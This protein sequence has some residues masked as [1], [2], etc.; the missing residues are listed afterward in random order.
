MI[1]P[2]PEQVEQ[3]MAERGG[4][5]FR[6]TPWATAFTIL[7]VALLIGLGTWQLQRLEWKEEL[8]AER[9]TRSTDSAVPL[10]GDLSD[11]KALDYVRVE[12]V[13]RFLHDKELY[14]GSRTL[15]GSVGYHVVTPFRLSD[16][17]TLLVNRGW[18]PP[19]RRDPES[20]AA[21]QLDGGEIRIEALLR[22]GGWRGWS[23]TRPANDP[24][25]N[26]WLWPDLPAMF[27][28]LGAE[29]AG[30]ERPVTTLYAESLPVGPLAELPGGL[31]VAVAGAIDLRN[32][33]LE[34]A[35]TWYALALALLIIYLIYSTRRGAAQP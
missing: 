11:S 18:V 9:H 27:A 25:G 7:G 29:A 34:Y 4:R 19:E 23:F 31:P 26:L 33:H 32:E 8:I 2:M 10:P 28:A 6:P 5:R 1:D 13:G 14:L 20:R 21:G 30:L 35:L 16:G 17:R 22:P 12:L 15:K 24:A 3:T